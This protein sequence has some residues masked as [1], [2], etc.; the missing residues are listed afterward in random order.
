MI[1]EK[2]VSNKNL[3]IKISGLDTNNIYLNFGAFGN[4]LSDISYSEYICYSNYNSEI[5]K[6][7]VEVWE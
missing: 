5:V 7:Y 6:V 3:G 2:L 1:T 4:N